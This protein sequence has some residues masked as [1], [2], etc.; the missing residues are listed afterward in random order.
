[1]AVTLHFTNAGI[2]AL[3]DEQ[4]TGTNARKVVALGLSPAPLTFVKDMTALPQEVKRLTMVGGMNVASNQLAIAARDESQDVYTV[5]S[6]GLYLDDGTLLAV[7]TQADVF[8]EKS[9][10]A[11]FLLTV[12]ALIDEAE[13]DANAIKFGDV[14]FTSP[15]AT[16]N[17]L[18]VVRVGTTPEVTAGKIG[19]PVIV[20]PLTLSKAFEEKLVDATE[21]IKGLALVAS[22]DQVLEGVHDGNVFINPALLKRFF[23][24]NVVAATTEKAGILRLA[25]N[26]EALAGQLFDVAVSP[27]AMHHFVTLRSMPIGAFVYSPLGTAPWGCLK[28]NGGWY[29]GAAYA[30]LFAAYGYRFGG[31]NADLFA[32]PDMRGVFPRVWDDGRG[33]DPGRQLMSWQGDAARQIYAEY[34]GREHGPL[35]W[36]FFKTYSVSDAGYTKVAGGYIG[37]NSALVWP[38]ANEFRPVSI[39]VAC[40]ITAFYK[41]DYR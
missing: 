21:K 37:F 6:F 3:I 16:D 35:S 13:I 36:P 31:N 38:T 14:L 28:A 17:T 33:T 4:H 5:R 15:P 26:A 20:N 32:V 19:G 12:D 40:Y 8:V 7:H 25:T 39:A 2:A 34:A 18:G 9:A 10:S 27:G 41:K 1:M 23:G 24:E 22:E 30:Q 11:V 29:A